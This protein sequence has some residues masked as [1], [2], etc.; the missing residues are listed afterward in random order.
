MRLNLISG[1]RKKKKKKIT[2]LLGCVMQDL[3]AEEKV[4][5]CISQRVYA[6]V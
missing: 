5:F 3:V 1:K 4:L 2:P 6:K